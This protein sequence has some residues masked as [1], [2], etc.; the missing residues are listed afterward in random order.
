MVF[1]IPRDKIGKAHVQ[2]SAQ[3][4]QHAPHSREGDTSLPELFDD[5]DVE[6]IC[7]GI[8]A[9]AAFTRWNHDPPLVPPLE[10]PGGDA[11]Q[12]KDIA[13]AE[14][15][16]QHSLANSRSKH[17]VAEMF[18]AILAGVRLAVNPYRSN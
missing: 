7:F 14:A 13:R 15:I 4:T 6:K 10:L 1:V 2:F 11:G 8:Y 3:Q 18:E 16:F 5:E 9:V 12:L 17:F